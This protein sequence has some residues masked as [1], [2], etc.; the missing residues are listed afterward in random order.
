MDQNEIDSLDY[1]FNRWK[2]EESS[3]LPKRKKVETPFEKILLIMYFITMIYCYDKYNVKNLDKHDQY[4][5]YLA[6][7]YNFI[8]YAF[9]LIFWCQ[10]YLKYE[11]K[12]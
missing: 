11:I 1:A 4:K 6:H 5:F 9:F 7:H 3:L 2:T 12:K 8:Q 10:P